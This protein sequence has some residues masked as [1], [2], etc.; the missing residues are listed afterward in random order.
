MNIAVNKQELVRSFHGGN[1]ELFAY[2]MHPD[3]HGYYE[4]L[5]AM[6]ESVKELFTHDVDKA[7]KLLA[8][9]GYPN[10]FSFRVQVCSC[11]PAH[12][13]LLELLS[14]Y[15]QKVGVKIQIQPMEYGA[16]FSSMMTKTH[17]PGYMQNNAHGSPTITLTKLFRSTSSWNVSMTKDAELDKRMVAMYAERS[18]AKRQQMLKDMNRELVALAPYVWLPTSKVYSAWW[19]WVKNYDGEL[20]G[21]GGRPGPVYARIWIDQEM[22]KKMGFN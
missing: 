3:W 8:E 4:P 5:S 2:P 6:P 1:A 11:A 20:R 17:A 14:G 15:Y 13:E 19:P 9:A 21:G 22:K 16:F 18:E 7:K 12:I 10:G